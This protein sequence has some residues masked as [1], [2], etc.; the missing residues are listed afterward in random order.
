MT[1]DTDGESRP[2]GAGMQCANRHILSSGEFRI[3]IYR[4]PLE[5]LRSRDTLRADLGWTGRR[6][7]TSWT[8]RGVGRGHDRRAGPVAS[9][10]FLLGL[11]QSATA[12]FRIVLRCST[13]P[14]TPSPILG[15]PVCPTAVRRAGRL[16]P[17]SDPAGSGAP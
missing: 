13:L 9:V 5:A 3:L 11:F 1:C 7:L 8:P 12:D 10:L 4:I 14:P 15:E 2:E 16:R 6:K 17:A